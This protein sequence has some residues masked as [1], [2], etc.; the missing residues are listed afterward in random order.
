M[1]TS[2]AEYRISLRADNADLRLTRKG[3]EYGLVHD[4]ERLAALAAREFMVEDR[5]ER[6]Q[7][8]NLKVVDWSE[9]GGD[10]MGGAQLG[11]KEGLR[12]SAEEILGMPH[13]TLEEVEKIMIDVQTELANKAASDD[14]TAASDGKDNIPS[15]E[16]MGPSPASIYDTVE[17]SIKYKN[18]VSRQ[19]RDMESWRR[20]QGL[21]IPP[22]VIY[23]LENLPT[24]SLE[25]LEKLNAARPATFAEASQISGITPQS[26]VYIYH[27]ICNRNRRRDRRVAADRPMQQKQQE[28]AS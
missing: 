5:I 17:A 26:L 16:V 20:A 9:R 25:E 13:V 24:L 2:R 18:Y 22:D 1:F 23:D 27:R 19:H 12:K 4:E 14:E 15:I 11:K 8:F 6:L 7:N 28:E 3:S 21:R 10:V